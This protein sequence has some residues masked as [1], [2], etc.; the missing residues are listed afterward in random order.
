M[1]VGLLAVRLLYRFYVCVHLSKWFTFFSV[2][3][4][5]F[6]VVVSS[7]TLAGNGFGLCVR[8][9]FGAQNCLPTLNLNRSTK[10][11]VC[12]SPRLTQNP[13]YLLGF[14]HCLLNTYSTISSISNICLVDAFIR[15][16][17]SF[18]INSFFLFLRNIGL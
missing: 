6:L 17:S 12:T 14:L 2:F 5:L 3:S 18:S 16:Y 8:A 10:L 13:C 9:G 15:I 7:F 4:R 1:S 11:Q